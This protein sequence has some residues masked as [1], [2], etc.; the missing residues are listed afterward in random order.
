METIVASLTSALADVYA[1]DGAIDGGGMSQV[2]AA[3][4]RALGRRVVI[5]VLGEAAR[6]VDAERFRQEILMSAA[7]QHPHIVPVHAAGEVSGLP[8]FVMPFVEGVSLRARLR[9]AGAI[10]IGEATRVL[11]DIAAALHYAHAR[12]IVHRDLKPENVMISGGSAVVLDFG[13]AKAIAAGA[14]GESSGLLT[15]A[16]YAVGTPRY[17]APE[18]AAADPALD[19]RAD[20]YTFGILAF[21]LFTGSPPFEGSPSDVL[22]RHIAEP[23]PDIAAVRPSLPAPLVTMVHAC[24]AKNPAD[25]PQN[26]SVV[27][28]LLDGVATPLS[29]T[30]VPAVQRHAPK[31]T[32]HGRWMEVL[33]VPA[34]Y[35]VAA[36]GVLAY[37]LRL[38]AQERVRDG[39]VA[40]GVIGSLIG[41]PIAVAGGLLLR[42]VGVERSK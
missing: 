33:A 5:K 21:E 3:T 31:R 27:L 16:G 10:Q 2:F 30:R 29:G 34:A 19:H 11:R 42:V 35:V 7:L 38:A 23:P 37:L 25:R 1:I 13:V 8:Y 32:K 14:R 41:L 18:Q 4:E 40:A 26:A 17:M 12:G 28:D 20:I 36:G 24:L 22:R 9:D 6:T 39:I 15:G